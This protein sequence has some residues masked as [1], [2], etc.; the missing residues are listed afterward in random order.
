MI[1]SQ[2]KVAIAIMVSTSAYNVKVHLILLHIPTRHIILVS[3]TNGTQPVGSHWLDNVANESFLIL[4]RE[5]RQRTALSQKP[6]A[7]E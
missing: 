7:S 4:L 5:L 3:E 2:I 1:G 6:L